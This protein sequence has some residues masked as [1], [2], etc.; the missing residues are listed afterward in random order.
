MTSPTDLDL[1]AALAD[2]VDH[3]YDAHRAG[4]ADEPEPYVT[5]LPVGA[6]FADHTYQRELDEHR[7][8]KMC[9]AFRIALVG[10][11]EVSDRGDGRYAILDGQHRW[12]TIR[13]RTFAEPREPHIACRVH[14]GLTID[15]EAA[16]YHELNTTRKQLTGWDRWLA[17]RG[18]GDPIVA[19]IETL[20]ARHGLRVALS[21]GA[22]VFR[23][24]RTAEK[25]VELNG[26][27]LL[28]EVIGVVRAAWPDD[29]SGL[30]GT[31][32]H[33]V[34]HVLNSY[35]RD[36]IDIPHLVASLAGVL[37]RQVSARAGAVRE[38]HKGTL[39]RLAAHVIVERYNTGKGQRLE[40]FFVRVR[41]VTKTQNAKT[42]HAAEYRAAA[43]TWARTTHHNGTV[44]HSRLSTGL[45][46][47][48]V[49]AGEPGAPGKPPLETPHPDDP[50][51][52]EPA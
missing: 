52:G 42:K 29:Q 18:A 44:Y 22:N 19:D 38:L 31:I 41:P 43:L 3:E 7:V 26:L 28:D 30:D 27:P 9:A 46:A 14:T 50:A 8:A 39:D 33:G 11:I 2:V 16:L 21:G 25:L 4:S 48:F 1:D 35:R 6:L 37:P 13:D 47:A 45:R 34:G 36:E 15:R 5:A 24:T 32:L 40:P 10:I 17:R 12:A 20:L 51:P 49:V 23:S